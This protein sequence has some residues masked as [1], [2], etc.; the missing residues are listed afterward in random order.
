MFEDKSYLNKDTI[1]LYEMFPNTRPGHFYVY[2]F[3]HYR[4]FRSI[5]NTKAV[6]CSPNPKQLWDKINFSERELQNSLN[7]GH[8]K[9]IYGGI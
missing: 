3:K 7:S 1:L 8:L 9:L 4:F 2:K 6:F 5:C